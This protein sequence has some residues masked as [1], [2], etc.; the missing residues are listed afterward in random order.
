M[1]DSE[2][3]MQFCSGGEQEL[4]KAINLYG[5]KLLRYVTA[6]LCDYQE[7][8]DIVQEVFVSAYRKRNSFDGKNLS[9][10]LY[11]IAHNYSIN[12]IKQRKLIYFSEIREEAISTVQNNG[13]SDETLQALRR[14][15]PK[16]RAV[17]YGRIIEELSYEELSCISGY[18]P[19]ALR[20]Q[21]ERAKKKLAEYLTAVKPQCFGEEKQ[22]ELN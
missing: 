16:E 3:G 22:N 18:S 2:L 6:I 12:R 11:K 5:E 8:E 19:S 4:E 15:K 20:K 10:W 14:L 21:Y 7:A 1:S 13:F 17:L 9:A